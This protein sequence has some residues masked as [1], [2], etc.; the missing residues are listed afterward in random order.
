MA[1]QLSRLVWD[2]SHIWT[3]VGGGG[4]SILTK[5]R[6]ALI[7]FGASASLLYS[8]VVLC[9]CSF[10]TK[11]VYPISSLHTLMVYVADSAYRIEVLQGSGSKRSVVFADVSIVIQ[12]IWRC[13]MEYDAMFR[14]TMG[15]SFEDQDKTLLKTIRAGDRSVP[16]HVRRDR[17]AA[18]S[19]LV[20]TKQQTRQ[21][22]EEDILLVPKHCDNLVQRHHNRSVL[23]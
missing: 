22:I 13:E 7:Y 19:I 15:T 17:P 20:V 21:V 6:S 3:M 18:G 5:K 16:I 2:A 14:P 4:C 11:R 23:L 1:P 9:P 12:S 8:A 10:A